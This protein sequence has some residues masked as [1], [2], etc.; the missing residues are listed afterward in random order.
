MLAQ[1]EKSILHIN[2]DSMTEKRHDSE[3]RNK[4]PNL[5]V[6]YSSRGQVSLV[7]MI[8]QKRKKSQDIR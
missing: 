1:K 5:M 4:N 2:Y 3:E 8:V 7:D 6:S